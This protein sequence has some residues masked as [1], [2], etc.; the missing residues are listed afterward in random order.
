MTERIRYRLIDPFA[1]GKRQRV[2]VVMFR[3]FEGFIARW[4]DSCSGCTELGDYGGGS[5]Y[6]DTDTKHHC[7]IGAGCEECGYTGK[8]RQEMWIPFDHAAFSAFD[9]RRWARRERL[10]AY[11]RKRAA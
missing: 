6:Y 4:T 8:R 9:D 2:K 1:D 11:F 3:G 10:I 5:Q 7:L